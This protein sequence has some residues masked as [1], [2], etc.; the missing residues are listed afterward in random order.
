MRF[1]KP[2]ER[3]MRC[4][5]LVGLAF[6]LGFVAPFAEQ[7]RVAQERIVRRLE[8]RRWAFDT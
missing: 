3:H 2:L 6:G 5:A 4:V 8:E 7:L 1:W